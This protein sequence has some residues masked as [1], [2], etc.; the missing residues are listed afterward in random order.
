MLKIY[1]TSKVKNYNSLNTYLSKIFCI[2][3]E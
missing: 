2:F 3:I 1:R